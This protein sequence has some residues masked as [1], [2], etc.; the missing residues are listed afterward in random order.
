MRFDASL[1]R[2]YHKLC[3]PLWPTRQ[4]ALSESI[5]GASAAAPNP[6][7]TSPS[8]TPY[9]FYTTDPGKGL[10]TGLCSDIN[11]VKGPI[12]RGLA[13]RAP[14]FH[15]GAAQNLTE[16]VN[17]Y[18]QRFQM[19]LMQEEMDRILEFALRIS[20][21]QIRRSS[22]LTPSLA[23][24][25]AKVSRLPIGPGLLVAKGSGSADPHEAGHIRDLP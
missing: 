13:A 10:V 22:P 24:R 14:Y 3:A 16:L 7:A 12:L 5:R 8:T 2:G 11:R 1:G 21:W 15:N 18:N 25:G 23:R 9:V 6:F 19:N 4:P 20:G 17:F